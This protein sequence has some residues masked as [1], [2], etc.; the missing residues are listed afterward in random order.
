MK[1]IIFEICLFALLFPM[2]GAAHD[3]P[4]KKCGT[5][6]SDTDLVLLHSDVAVANQTSVVAK[7][8]SASRSKRW[9]PIGFLQMPSADVPIVGLNLLSTH[10][11]VYG[12]SAGILDMDGGFTNKMYGLSFNA[13]SN[14][15]ESGA[16]LFVAGMFNILGDVAPF[17]VQL[18][19]GC[20]MCDGGAAIQVGC[21]NAMDDSFGL[22]FGC[23]NVM[24]D[25]SSGMQV[26]LYNSASGNTRCFQ[27]GAVNNVDSSSSC[28]QFGGFNFMKGAPSGMQ[29]GLY[30]STS[31]NARCFQLG[32]VNNVDSS[33]SCLQVGVLNFGQNALVFFPVIRAQW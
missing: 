28:L 18:A 20:N 10:S 1:K 23:F 25:A 13:L 33:S 26:G 3:R 19:I 31:G 21:L 14:A 17:V 32:A 29:V 8:N 7:V 4:C 22:Q 9:S 12:V 30:N 5:S 27:L 6:H 15:H 11:S 2:V 24:K 16:G